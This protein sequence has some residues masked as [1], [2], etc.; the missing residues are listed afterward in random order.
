MLVLRNR[1]EGA[2]GNI[3]LG[4]KVPAPRL[5]AGGGFD[6]SDGGAEIIPFPRQLSTEG[7]MMKIARKHGRWF[8]LA[9]ILVFGL[10]CVAAP[11]VLI[12]R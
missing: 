4:R 5:A 10:A 2:A 6:G 12:P 11:S 1:R 9:A 3:E 7:F 8:G